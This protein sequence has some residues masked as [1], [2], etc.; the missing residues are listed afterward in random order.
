MYIL[1]ILKSRTSYTTNHFDLTKDAV[2]CISFKSWNQEH[3]IQHTKL[4]NSPS[5]RCVYPSNLEI[6]NILYNLLGFFAARHRVVYIL[7]ILKS[8]TSYTTIFITFVIGISC[9]YPS[10]LEIKNILYNG[11]AQ[12]NNSGSLCISFK[13]WN[14]EHPIQLPTVVSFCVS[15]C[16]YPSNLEI[17]NILYNVS[18]ARNLSSTVVYILQILKSRTSYTTAYFR[19]GQYNCCVYPSNLEIKNILYNAFSC[20]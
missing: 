3:P 15:C 19:H 8:R 10:N 14:Q 1:Q 18:L 17:K 13:S 7:Q 9:V 11:K 16:V 12:T 2:L 6:K 20:R 5:L 4:K